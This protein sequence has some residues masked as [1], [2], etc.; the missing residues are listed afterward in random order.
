MKK[1]HMHTELSRVKCQVCGKQLKERIVEQK[2]P[3]NRR[4]CYSCYAALR[5]GYVYHH[6]DYPGVH[7][8]CVT[9]HKT[10]VA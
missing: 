10:A 6:V 1:T 5:Y 4:Y 2:E 8:E 9:S 7:R 3:Q